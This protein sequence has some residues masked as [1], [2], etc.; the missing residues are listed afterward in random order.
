MNRND[1]SNGADSGA[2][3]LIA[4]RY[5]IRRSIGSGGAGAVFQA[6]DTQLNRPVA[7]KRWNAP[8]PMLDD[9]EGTERLWREAMTLAAIQHPNI[10]TIHD[11]GVDDEGPYVIT[12]FV[13]GETLD[14]AVEQAPFDRDAF[15]EAAQQILEGLIAAHQAGLIHR[16]LKP[17][18]I[19]RTRLPSGAWQY[20]ILDFGLARFVTRPTVQSL[21]GNTSIYGS[22]LYIAPEQLRHQPLDVR[23]DIYAFGCLCYYMLAGR[24]AIDGDTIPDL[25]TR[26]LEH[27]VKPLAE[28]RPD[29][30]AGLCDWVMKALSFDP[31]DRFPSAAAALAALGQVLPG[32]IRK[33]TVRIP[34]PG[35]APTTTP[36]PPAAPPPRPPRPRKAPAKAA[37]APAAWIRWAPAAAALLLVAAAIAVLISHRRSRAAD[38]DTIRYVTVEAESPTDATIVESFITVWPRDIAPERRPLVQHYFEQLRDLDEHKW[39]SVGYVLEALAQIQFDARLD[40]DEFTTLCNLTYHDTTM[41]TLGELDVVIWNRKENRAETAFEAAVSDQLHRKAVP[42]RNQIARFGRALEKGEVFRILCPTDDTRTLTPEQFRHTRL[43]I[44]GNQGAIAAGFDAEVDITRPEVNFLQRKLIDWR[45]ARRGRE[46][47]FAE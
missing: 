19:M 1:A 41:R 45:K 3:G 35:Q 40:P 7:V 23:T 2:A 31:A 25:I 32:S 18:N 42:S 8:E 36:P 9:R 47:P 46:G 37:A 13:D 28:W 21:E 14:R 16:D 26:H 15:A 6:W 34:L 38:D 29:L 22:I 39:G 27:A 20:K 30:P 11:F 43:E 4:D 10:L 24:N 12:E 5:E 17:Q 33:T 44:L